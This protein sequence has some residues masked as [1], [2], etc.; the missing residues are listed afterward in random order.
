MNT[1][2]R[3]S[4]LAALLLM[5]GLG[6]LSAQT[7]LFSDNFNRT[8][9]A[10]GNTDLLY[11]VDFSTTGMGGTLIT[12]GTLSVSNAWLEPVDIGTANE[13]RSQIS[14]NDQLRLAVGPGTTHIVLSN[15]F[16]TQLNTSGVLS[17]EI[18]VPAWLSLDAT[19]L[20]R[21]MGIGIGGG[22]FELNVNGDRALLRGAD[23]FV[24]LTQEG[25]VRINDALPTTR[26]AA[27]DVPANF[28]YDLNPNAT[29][30]IPGKL[31]VD[32][33]VSNTDFNSTVP[34]DVYFDSGSGYQHIITNRSFV[35]TGQ[36]ELFIGLD[37]RHAVGVPG[38]DF[39]VT[40]TEAS[41]IPEVQLS[42]TPTEVGQ[43]T[44]SSEVNLTFSSFNLPS[45]STY[46][47]VADK[48]VTYPF[49]NN[50]G[51]A[52]FPSLPIPAQVNG[53]LGDVT[54][55]I[56]I[57]NTVPAL[58]ATDSVTVTAV[59]EAGA[60]TSTL[61]ADT[62]NRAFTMPLNTDIDSGTDGM[63]GPLSPMTYLEV[64]EGASIGAT[65]YVDSTTYIG[66]DS[67]G[68]EVCSMAN[69]PVMSIFGLD[70]NFTNTAILTDGGFSVALDV[71]EINS[72]TGDGGD[73]Y[74]GFG[75]GLSLAEVNAFMDE[76]TGNYSGPR[77]GLEGDGFRHAG[78]ADFFVSLA[79]NNNLQIFAGGVIIQEVNVITNR[80][81]IR[82]DFGV[83]DFNAGS[84]VAYK[85]YYN[86]LLKAQGFFKWTG[87]NQNYVAVSG[88]GSGFVA[89][90]N[91][92]IGTISVPFGAPVEHPDFN[93]TLASLTPATPPFASAT[94]EFPS[95]EGVTYRADIAAQVTDPFLPAGG[96]VGGEAVFTATSTTTTGTMNVP[97]ANTTSSFIR[98]L[99]VHWSGPID[100]PAAAAQ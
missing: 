84:Y 51:S 99:P 21:Y 6:S 56:Y 35:W 58:I 80:G 44:T 68:N 26:P 1:P 67:L 62:F 12:G 28:V 94:V 39:A 92:A 78:T 100:P 90:D 33:K 81:R 29:A 52:E 55:T 69:G 43:D 8:A 79:I 36:D 40:F 71:A 9:L 15:N 10:G 14:T 64:W 74:G 19:P 5:T 2:K 38:D 17:V 27:N 65:N 46:T 24:A 82:A 23:L 53:T 11:D 57:S 22:E 85:V 93:L 77:G 60:L 7:V 96:N 32:L 70:Y 86:N 83:T 18:A 76:N 42:V 34:Y 16:A 45:G 30:F 48:A 31:R 4:H 50:T 73:R 13:S 95:V 91:L 54:F 37:A 72:I 75:V 87:T 88:R 25:T 61:F 3:Y 66:L 47:V 89:I 98:V 49:A 20:H 41:F 59:E 63:S 97:P